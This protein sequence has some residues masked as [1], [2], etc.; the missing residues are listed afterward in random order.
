M[1]A[2][3]GSVASGILGGRHAYRFVATLWTHTGVLLPLSLL[4]LNSGLSVCLIDS[5]QAV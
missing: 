3:V 2:W 4:F 1:E 5:R